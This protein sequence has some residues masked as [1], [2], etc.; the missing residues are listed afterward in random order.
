MNVSPLIPQSNKVLAAQYHYIAANANPLGAKE[1]LDAHTPH[2]APD[3]RYAN[4]HQTYHPIFRSFLQRF[5]YYDIF[6]VEPEQGH[7][8]YSVFKELDYGTSLTSGPYKDTNFARAYRQALQSGETVLLDFETYGPSYDA[9][10]SFIATPIWAAPGEIAGV[11][12]FQMPVDNINSI[13][14]Q[15]AGLG[16]TGE[17]VLVGADGLLRSQ[18][19]FTDENTILERVMDGEFTQLAQQGEKGVGQFTVDQSEALVAFAPLEIEGLSWN[20]V[21]FIQA[22]EALSAVSGL[23][24]SGLLNSLIM[25]PIIGALI[26]WL[27]RYVAK[28]LG[29]DPKRLQ[30]VAESIAHGDLELNMQSEDGKDLVGVFA[31]MRDMRDNLKARAKA[32]QEAAAQIK[33][34]AEDM[35]TQAMVSGRIKEALDNV[36]SCVIVADAQNKVIYTNKALNDLFATVAAS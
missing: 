27:T 14:Q 22:D 21:G 26:W 35:Q 34:Q 32:D 10:A 11:L 19:R 4:W 16:E 18:S 31:A 9:P 24:N 17:T 23:T 12:I 33:Q 30:V 15:H 1:V 5:G 13:M 3:T 7:I 6:L 28:V 20:V 8:V 25:L 36:S 29:S 2:S